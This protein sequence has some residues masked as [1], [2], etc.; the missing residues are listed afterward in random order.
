M[1]KIL[2]LCVAALLLL[3]LLPSLPV[4]AESYNPYLVVNASERLTVADVVFPRYAPDG[5][6]IAFIAKGLPTPS[7]MPS[8]TAPTSI[9]WPSFPTQSGLSPS[10]RTAPSWR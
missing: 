1:R 2:I 3:P 10:S 7:S 8:R 4:Q 6:Y 9:R 5:S